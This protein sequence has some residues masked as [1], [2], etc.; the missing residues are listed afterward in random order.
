MPHGR[1]FSV[2]LTS[3]WFD[4]FPISFSYFFFV[5]KDLI[6]ITTI[7]FRVTQVRIPLPGVYSRYHSCCSTI[8]CEREIP[9]SH[10]SI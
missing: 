3:R 7:A 4:S 6:L 5:S 10:T 2:P 1:R 8:H 9:P